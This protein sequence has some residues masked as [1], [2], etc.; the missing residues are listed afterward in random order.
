MADMPESL[1]LADDADGE[2]TI[3]FDDGKRY[4]IPVLDRA[5]VV[6]TTVNVQLRRASQ[7][8]WSKLTADLPTREDPS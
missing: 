6:S 1:Y 4:P 5:E 7:Y 3:W 8:L 2:P